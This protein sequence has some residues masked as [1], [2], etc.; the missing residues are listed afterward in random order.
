MALGLKV[1]TYRAL[2]AVVTALIVASGLC[3]SAV[4][5]PPLAAAALFVTIACTAGIIS[6]NLHLLA[7]KP[8]PPRSTLVQSVATHALVSASVG[9]ACFGFAATIG[10]HV[11]LVVL[12][13][14]ITAP[15][16]LTA[17]VR[18]LGSAPAAD[19]GV[20]SRA[21]LAEWTDDDLYSAWCSSRTGVQLPGQAID[22]ARVRGL[23]LEEFEKRY[24]AE[25]EAWLRSG[26]S[27]SGSPPR[28]L[29]NAGRGHD[30]P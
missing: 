19:Q 8:P 10:P 25:T 27:L 26:T 6:A 16:V 5:A 12:L 9:V 1:G 20:L 13:L 29:L 18:W 21:E 2:W 24:P 14:V 28:F 15:P 30:H 23:L 3:F 4:A 7:E 22:A 17:V 11:L